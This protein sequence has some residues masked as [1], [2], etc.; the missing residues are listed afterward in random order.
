MKKLNSY[1][2][3]RNPDNINWLTARL[4][5]LSGQH[6]KLGKAFQFASSNL[7]HEGFRAFSKA[8]KTA[9]MDEVVEL[10]RAVLSHA[11]D[12]LSSS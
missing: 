8:Y 11:Q 2:K 6:G 1:D 10:T 4:V 7:G 9:H 3:P 12:S 5:Y